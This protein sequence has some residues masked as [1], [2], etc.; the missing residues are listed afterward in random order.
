M[1][2]S[3]AKIGNALSEFEKLRLQK[4]LK[5]I[6]P[7]E[8]HPIILRKFIQERLLVIYTQNKKIHSELSFQKLLKNFGVLS[9]ENLE[10]NEYTS[11]TKNPYVLFP[12]KNICFLNADTLPILAEDKDLYEQNYLLFI[13]QKLGPYEKKDWCHCL[14]VT[15]KIGS[16]RERNIL[17]YHI[18]AKKNH[19]NQHFEEEYIPKYLEDIFPRNT[20]HP[21]SWFY[22]GVITFY[23][24]LEETEKKLN[25]YLPIV[26]KTIPLFK[27]G[28]LV[29]KKNKEMNKEKG[30]W[31]IVRV[32]EK[33]IIWP[34][35]EFTDILSQ[36]LLI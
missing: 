31:K 24:A 6:L 33:D 13:I 28:R 27:L 7:I 16:E 14:K 9:R 26:Q 23:K 1:I 20:L 3:L 19:L 17:L 18:L 2:L 15:K 4:L 21:M 25:S 12:S 8:K 29:I 36:S 5:C 32:S 34:K 22:R 11:L 10:E 35:E 30:L